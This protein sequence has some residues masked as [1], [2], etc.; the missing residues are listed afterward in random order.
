MFAGFGEER[1][2]CFRLLTALVILTVGW[3]HQA[4]ANPCLGNEAQQVFIGN[5][6]YT[7]SSLNELSDRDLTAYMSGYSDAYSSGPIVGIR[8]ECHK[9]L[10]S[11]VVGRSNTQLADMV[12]KYLR[13]NPAKWHEPA[14]VLVYTAVFN[15]CMN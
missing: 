1:L 15:E 13:D 5:G 10:M 2:A 7:G 9:R 3:T 12:R 8:P 14:G 4:S 6:F 11:C